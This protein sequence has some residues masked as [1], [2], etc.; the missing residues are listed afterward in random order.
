MFIY[1]IFLLY[2]GRIFISF[3]LLISNSKNNN[4]VN[5]LSY[6]ISLSSINVTYKIFVIYK[7]ITALY[8]MVVIFTNLIKL[9]YFV[10]KNLYKLY[11][12]EYV[13]FF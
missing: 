1:F 4:K 8:E 13:H 12:V 5:H 3:S 7:Q 10:I 2:F 6:L 9:I 11:K